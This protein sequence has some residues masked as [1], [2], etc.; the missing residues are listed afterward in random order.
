METTCREPQAMQ[1]WRLNGRNVLKKHRFRPFKRLFYIYS[2]FMGLAQNSYAWDVQS[3]VN[4][5]DL[6]I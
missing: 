2:P 4:M 6:F 5:D 3:V 1:K